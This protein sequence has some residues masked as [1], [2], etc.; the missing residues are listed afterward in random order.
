[1][2]SASLNKTFPSFLFSGSSPDETR[3]TAKHALRSVL[4]KSGGESVLVS[5]TTTPA[6]S[7][8]DG[9][10]SDPLLNLEF[11]PNPPGQDVLSPR[12]Q[13]H[14]DTKTSSRCEKKK[15]VTRSQSYGCSR[16]PLNRNGCSNSQLSENK[17]LNVSN[18][19]DDVVGGIANCVKAVAKTAAAN[20]G[21]GHKRSRSDMC[22]TN[23]NGSSDAVGQSQSKLVQAASSFPSGP[24]PVK[25]G[26]TFIP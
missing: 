17:D 9:I 21:L 6:F 15:S 20:Q 22:P 19:S 11:V 1:M 16:S 14:I 13:E 26:E 23:R 10:H 2:L 24:Q 3:N 25:R 5:T 12:L 7:L 18:N 8:Y 4:N